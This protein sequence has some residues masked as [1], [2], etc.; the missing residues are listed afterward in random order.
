MV[1]IF[2][3]GLQMFHSHISETKY[4]LRN[5][6]VSFVVRLIFGCLLLKMFY[7]L[8]TLLLAGSLHIL[9]LCI[10]FLLLLYLNVWLTSNLIE[11]Y[12]I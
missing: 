9:S 6:L 7:L 8:A 2:H 11:L 4:S 1:I 5:L 12:F 10:D 3:L